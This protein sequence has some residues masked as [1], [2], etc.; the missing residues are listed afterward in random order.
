MRNLLLC[1]TMVR[2]ERE[3]QTARTWD[4]PV[5]AG[6]FDNMK[7]NPVEQRVLFEKSVRTRCIKL[8]GLHAADGE[9][10]MSAAEVGVI[11]RT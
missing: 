10:F 1:P 8:R 3:Q 5:S 6:R 9:P 2:S 7:N 11:T 4:Y